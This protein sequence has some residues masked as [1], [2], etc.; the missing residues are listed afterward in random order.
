MFLLILRRAVALPDGII[1]RHRRRFYP[2]TT[3]KTLAEDANQD[4]TRWASEPR[5]FHIRI[6]QKSR[7][8][9]TT[10]MMIPWAW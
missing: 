5:R 6:G 4:N 1:M 2:Q 10:S 3:L 8:A 7:I 9:S